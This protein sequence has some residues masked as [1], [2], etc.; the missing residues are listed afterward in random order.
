MAFNTSDYPEIGK[1]A[2][3][4]D[5]AKSEFLKLDRQLDETPTASLRTINL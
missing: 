2:S 1:A 3:A 5:V 4:Y